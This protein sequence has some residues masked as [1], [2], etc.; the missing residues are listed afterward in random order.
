MADPDN[1]INP[2]DIILEKYLQIYKKYLAWAADEL[3]RHFA[4]TGADLFRNFIWSY[5][6]GDHRHYY[7][8]Q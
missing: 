7:A 2:D 1:C 8:Y 4:D 3:V 6:T 5:R